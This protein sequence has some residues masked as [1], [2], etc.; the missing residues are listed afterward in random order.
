M[1]Q[2]MKIRGEIM[3]TLVKVLNQNLSA[4][5]YN[6]SVI[7]A[8]ISKLDISL[9]ENN[10]KDVEDYSK[11]VEVYEYDAP[12]VEIIR[13]FLNINNEFIQSEVI[14]GYIKT[15]SAENAY[16]TR[17]VAAN[18]S[19]NKRSA[20]ITVSNDFLIKIYVYAPTQKIQVIY[21]GKTYEDLY[22]KERD[23]VTLD[24][25]VAFERK[26][27]WTAQKIEEMLTLLVS[28]YIIDEMII[29]NKNP[30]MK[31]YS[32]PEKYAENITTYS[33]RFINNRTNR[34]EIY[35]KE[36][37]LKRIGNGVIAGVCSNDPYIR[38]DEMPIQTDF[39]LNRIS[40]YWFVNEG[41]KSEEIAI[42][43][44]DNNTEYE[45]FTELKK[46]SPS[47]N[48]IIDDVI[49]SLR[50]TVRVE[51]DYSGYIKE[52]IKLLNLELVNPSVTTLREKLEN[53]TDSITPI[54]YRYNFLS[55]PK[56]FEERLYVSIEDN[57]GKEYKY[58]ISESIME[59]L[60]HIGNKLEY[61]DEKGEFV[62]RQSVADFNVNAPAAI[63]RK[64]TFISADRIP[65]LLGY[66]YED[67]DS[68]G[69]EKLPIPSIYVDIYIPKN[70][71]TIVSMYNGTSLDFTLDGL[72]KNKFFY[73]SD[74]KDSG[75]IEG[76]ATLPGSTYVTVRYV[77]SKGEIL[78]ENKIGNLFPNSTFVPEILPIINDTHGKEWRAELTRLEP[79]VVQS[80]PEK[81]II[82][83]KYVERFTRVSFSFINIQE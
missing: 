27:K 61:T 52:A 31:P 65:D 21:E 33:L 55:E 82:Q 72:S 81:N 8:V 66:I 78:K 22:K 16:R 28:D 37:Q 46:N 5:G 7:S 57:I 2:K 49:K 14:E 60:T 63:I 30:T 80:D 9:I 29:G 19:L 26:K 43:T 25:K 79:L 12:C 15:F 44:A 54:S 56:E 13:A 41:K 39:S 70:P 18:Y 50:R 42:Y 32:D 73:N 11:Y 36:P 3:N 68:Y 69:T 76:G 62:R 71:S 20:V 6:E 35:E 47:I 58:K 51:E 53:I 38:L 83:L 40:Y 59:D 64:E 75:Y 1:S 77:N 23:S 17:F 48:L 67:L 74:T 10:L 24:Y 45:T 4:L 34:I